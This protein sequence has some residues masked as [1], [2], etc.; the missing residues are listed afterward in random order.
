MAISKILGC[1]VAATFRPRQA[2]LTDT[3][4]A[5]SEGC[6]LYIV[7]RR[8]RTYIAD[9]R[10]DRKGRI[11]GKIVVH[12]GEARK[13]RFSLD[14]GLS[15]ELE[16]KSEKPWIYYMI[17]ERSSGKPIFHGD[18]WG[19]S[20]LASSYRED[21]T[22]H[23]VLYIG[24]AFGKSGERTALDR[25][26]R[27][28]T[29]QKIYSDHEHQEY[30]IFVTM[31]RVSEAGTW[32]TF[33]GAGSFEAMERMGPG[34]FVNRIFRTDEDK[35]R[36]Q[37]HQAEAALIGYF[38]PSDYNHQHLDFL[39]KKS[40]LAENIE[41]EGFTSFRISLEDG[42]TGLKFWSKTRPPTRMHSFEYRTRY[43]SMTPEIKSD[44]DE[45]TETQDK[46]ISRYQEA[47]SNSPRV[48]SL[49]PVNMEFD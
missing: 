20:L 24:R 14:L 35:L 49:I 9:A 17:S 18:T 23:E 15:P 3:F 11:K 47:V 6:H 31:L 26:L 38:R 41:A 37:V 44:A 40:D 7:S 30:D 10:I 19:L 28:E 29:L 45:F 25:V 48:L 4:R 21:L 36:E 12:R 43:G 27:H 5:L 33:S 16:W 2:A 42:S 8:P 13:K 46:F 32:I 34:G 22:H 1:D 39:R